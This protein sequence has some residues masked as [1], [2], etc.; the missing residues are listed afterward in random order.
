[1]KFNIYNEHYYYLNKKTAI[2][3]EKC[4]LED[5]P[6]VQNNNNIL[7]TRNENK[8]IYKLFSSVKSINENTTELVD[9]ILSGDTIH[10][11]L[12][13]NR[14][15]KI[16]FDL[17]TTVNTWG[18][19]LNLRKNLIEVITDKFK[20][21]VEDLSRL[22]IESSNE[23][24]IY[25]SP[26]INLTVLDNSRQISYI[27]RES[28]S[29]SSYEF[30]LN[31][32][33]CAEDSYNEI[34]Y[35]LSLHIILN[36]TYMDNIHSVGK[37]VKWFVSKY[38]IDL[39]SDYAKCFDL[40]VYRQNGSLRLPF[41]SKLDCMNNKC[42]M[43]PI[44]II[45]NDYDSNVNKKA[46]LK[47]SLL[48]Y[49]E[50]ENLR[51]FTHPLFSQKILSADDEDK[52]NVINN[53]LSTCN[54]ASVIFEQMS[55]I[56]ISIKESYTIREVKSN[57]IYLQ[58][59][60]AS[61]CKLCDR[62]HDKEGAYIYIN[63]HDK[64]IRCIFKCYR[65]TN[66]SY[67]YDIDDSE[68]NKTVLDLCAANNINLNA[69]KQNKKKGYEILEA[70]V[71][72]Q[73][74]LKYKDTLLKNLAN[75]FTNTDIYSSQ[76]MKDYPISVAYKTYYIRAAM[77]VGKTIALVN[78]IK[79]RLYYDPDLL[80]VIISFRRT[81]SA[82][83]L[84]D[85]NELNFK[86]YSNIDGSI[87]DRRI[88]LQAES[89]LRLYYEPR[90]IDILIMD[91]VKSIYSQITNNTNNANFINSFAKIHKSIQ[92]ADTVIIADA[93]LDAT[94][95]QSISSVRDDKKSI[96]IW[97]TYDKEINRKYSITT[98]LNTILSNINNSIDTSEKIAIIS[99]S[100][101]NSESLRKILIEV[102][103]V[104]EDQIL[105]Y[106]SNTDD[107]IKSIHFKDV[108]NYWGKARVVIYTSTVKAGISC[109]EKFDVVYGF[110]SC[111]KTKITAE[112]FAQMLGRIR[113]CD[114]FRI[115]VINSTGNYILDPLYICNSLYSSYRVKLY[116]N[117]EKNINNQL[118]LYKR[119]LAMYIYIAAK[120]IL[121]H[122]KK[123][124]IERICSIFKQYGA[125]LCIMKFINTAATELQQQQSLL[126]DDN[127][128]SS[129]SHLSIDGEMLKAFNLQVSLAES[130]DIANAEV[131]S[132]EK[133]E[134]LKQR[135]SCGKEITY[136]EKNI[137][138]KEEIRKIYNISAN[139]ITESFVFIYYNPDI[140]KQYNTL[141]LLLDIRN[142]SDI[143]INS[144]LNRMLTNL[145]DS[146][147]GALK[148]VNYTSNNYILFL[149][150]RLIL[151]LGFKHWFDG[152]NLTS[153]S[154]LNNIARNRRT[155]IN[156]LNYIYMELK[157]FRNIEY[158]ASNEKKILKICQFILEDITSIK[159]TSEKNFSRIIWPLDLFSFR[160]DNRFNTYNNV[161]MSILHNCFGEQID[162]IYR[163]NNNKPIVSITYNTISYIN[164]ML[165][166]KYI[167]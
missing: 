136:I 10:E 73:D 135:V 167:M 76:Y 67:I 106:N 19:I 118:I 69:K 123:N 124:F 85:L 53:I 158:V 156:I 35:K 40:G 30:L 59:Q 60:I 98:D 51:P 74:N 23:V 66:K 55:N 17:E 47:D 12:L 152:A 140:I 100:K 36:N 22:N 132:R 52:I 122:T 81:F 16:F 29:R 21:C 96:L 165:N 43:K 64:K 6:E 37:F 72:N 39:N 103:K 15:T 33:A 65:N 163:E 97:N 48:Q 95:A 5:Y 62:N 145:I 160:L 79:N 157:N 159:I 46:T 139:C 80:V 155:I 102:K 116:L 121:L 27:R 13:A 58:R 63:I 129:T 153:D 93:F 114:D 127:N 109:T 101:K 78:Y 88:I 161:V 92:L 57:I 87:Y 151:L 128:S 3:S 56:N 105:L 142:Y 61:F 134:E 38:I 137:L 108:N 9:D 99:F 94:I 20:T 143:K 71:N 24:I 113:N 49:I 119:D 34:K 166:N 1:M 2:N 77:G 14:Y 147:A 125:E 110:L 141:N 91:E 112:D 44:N 45:T 115:H 75:V 50:Y 84:S 42:F 83:I 150:H 7:I 164:T 4:L 18:E 126:A 120:L 25:M 154:I 11:V 133:Y 107:K 130:R 117:I 70:I 31:K 146:K 26:N 28:I 86:L 144:G 68:I 41:T 111:Y 131:I 138:K 149:M 32:N 162:Y 89:F 8:K 90:E 148:F 104:P 82:K 54:Y